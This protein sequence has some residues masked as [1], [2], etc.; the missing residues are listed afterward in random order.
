[1]LVVI[2]AKTPSGRLEVRE[3]PETKVEAGGEATY[4]RTAVSTADQPN[5]PSN[6]A[7][8]WMNTVT[9]QK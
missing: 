3:N 4:N 6:H 5:Q 1:M 8:A 2:K 9:H 7:V